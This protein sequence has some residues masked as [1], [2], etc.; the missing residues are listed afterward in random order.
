[1]RFRIHPGECVRLFP[2]DD[3]AQGECAGHARD[4]REVCDLPVPREGSQD[5]AEGYHF[6]RRSGRRI[7][8]DE[9]GTE[10]AGSRA[11]AGS[12]GK[13][14]SAQSLADRDHNGHGGGHE[15]GTDCLVRAPQGK[16]R[17]FSFIT[18]SIFRILM[19]RDE[20]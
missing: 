15:V 17:G 18:C 8:G 11:A 12:S 7:L 2:R 5:R 10:A 4:D 14:S 16:L 3:H 1:M 9:S 20:L 13:G 6:S 19:G